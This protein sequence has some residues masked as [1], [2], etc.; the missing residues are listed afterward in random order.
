ME[1]RDAGDLGRLVKQ[2]RSSRGLSQD[3]LASQTGVSRSTI[4]D[5]EH[6]R[7]ISIGTAL[8]VL[9]RFDATLS[10]PAPKAEP[11]LHWTADKA[12]RAIKRELNKGDPDFA[13]RTLIM[14]VDYFE[15]LDSRH[16]RLFLSAAPSSTGRKRWD[17]LL[18]RAFA[19]RC[20]EHGMKAP[21][22]TRVDP[23]QQKWYATPRRH[24]SE[25]W[26][27]RMAQRTPA[28]FAD[29]NIVFD[30]KNLASV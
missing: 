22:W 23:L 15:N 8:K 6:G 14:A 10:A 30:A 4:V 19:Y 5:L 17:A 2:H 3:E 13:M 21:A 26:K 25:A 7:N 28:E 20:R 18:S 11:E 16:R 12:A 29:A 27:Q 9:S 1:I 24:P